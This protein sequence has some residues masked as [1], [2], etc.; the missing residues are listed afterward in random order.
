MVFGYY[1]ASP[2]PVGGR[3]L[4]L[5]QQLPLDGLEEGM[6]H[7]LHESRLLVAAQAVS[8]ILVEE[9]LQDA[10]RFH[11]QG[12]RDPDGLLQDHLQTAKRLAG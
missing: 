5:L 4:L 11:G 6:G 2:G 1:Y 3:D 8:R 7:D 12:P 10:R 9:S